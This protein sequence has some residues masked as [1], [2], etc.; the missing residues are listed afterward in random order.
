MAF[1]PSEPRNCI[2]TNMLVLLAR[3]ITEIKRK[4]LGSSSRRRLVVILRCIYRG[5]DS[6]WISVWVCILTGIGGWVK[7]FLYV[8]FQLVCRNVTK[9]C[10]CWR[11]QWSFDVII[12]LFLSVF[13]A[14]AEVLDITCC[15]D[16]P[17]PP[18]FIAVVL[19]SLGSPLLSPLSS[20]SSPPRSFQVSSLIFLGCLVG[21]CGECV[22]VCPFTAAAG[23]CFHC[24]ILQKIWI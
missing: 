12:D 17:R 7:C 4:E 20:S 2:G 23:H 18:L 10:Y 16:S 15:R 9:S 11:H 5:L 22:I 21:E 24:N 6:R 19:T 13:P 1:E 14:K 3:F 8:I